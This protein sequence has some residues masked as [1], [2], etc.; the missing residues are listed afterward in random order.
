[1]I[2]NSCA[3]FAPDRSG[4]KTTS[5]CLPTGIRLLKSHYNTSNIDNI[6]VN[7]IESRMCTDVSC[8]RRYKKKN[9]LLSKKQKIF[10]L[11][12]YIDKP[13]N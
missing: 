3:C 11:N 8:S 12:T 2:Y 4:L 13:M 1:M 9:T 5:V 6:D 7:I 10:L